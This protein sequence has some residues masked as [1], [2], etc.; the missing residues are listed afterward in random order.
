MI[1]LNRKRAEKKQYNGFYFL[2]FLC[3]MT[4]PCNCFD[5]IAMHPSTLWSTNIVIINNGSLTANNMPFASIDLSSPSW[6]KSS[7]A[8]TIAL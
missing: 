7:N 1:Q 5:K 6:T 3:S 4:I 2:K 8:L